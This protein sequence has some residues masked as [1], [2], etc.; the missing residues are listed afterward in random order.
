VSGTEA[1][2]RELRG[3]NLALVRR[4]L[5]LA[6]FLLGTGWLV[7]AALGVAAAPVGPWVAAVLLGLSLLLPVLPAYVRWTGAGG[8]AVQLAADG[9]ATGLIVLFA[10]ACGTALPLLW[11]VPVL[12]AVREERGLLAARLG[13]AG[14]IAI[15]GLHLAVAV[16]LLPDYGRQAAVGSGLAWVSTALGA[17][18]CLM[19]GRI[20]R[21]LLR[22]AHT[23]QLLQ[24][25]VGA[26]VQRARNELRSILDNISSGLIIVDQR[27]V[28][29]RM[30]P[31]AARI[32]GR[33][34]DAAVGQPLMAVLG[35][36]GDSFTHAVTQVA[37]GGGPLSRQTLE[38][39]RDNQ[40][41]PVGLSVSP[42]EDRNGQAGG[43]IAIFKDLTDV[44][45]L[46]EQRREADRLAAVGELAA[47]IAHEIRNPL[48]S[49]RGSVEILQGELSL[50]GHQAK[51]LQL[52]I[53]ESAR[54]N[55]IIDEFL[56]FARLRPAEPRLVMCEEFLEGVVLQIRQHIAAQSGQVDVSHEA[57]RQD[58]SIMIDPEQM[59]QLF[60]NLAINAC[61]AMDYRGRLH[62]EA[63][64]GREEG[65][66]ELCVMDSGP[67][68]PPEVA[69]KIFKPFVTTKKGGTGLGLP[70]VARIAHGHGGSVHLEPSALGGACFRVRLGLDQSQPESSASSRPACTVLPEEPAVTV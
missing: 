11:C 63:A 16:G 62:L 59:T 51:L 53:K 68:V 6:A 5:P 14:S 65:R 17:G 8:P 18:I 27:A 2:V 3:Q 48:G 39:E 31:A 38:I 1:T 24:S 56:A 22:R 54:V 19:C 66:C 44:V 69:G 28:V 46:Q 52:I 49:I 10:G 25:Q 67:G 30:N 21:G 32:L 42:M 58:L 40:T 4:R 50:S 64:A 55:D 15:I 70:M 60:L 47:S 41:V 9:V 57:T 13:A 33:Q 26:Q 20:G 29:T 34:T 37:E 35:T 36:G 43:A 23:D 61:E 7:R 12:L 45:R